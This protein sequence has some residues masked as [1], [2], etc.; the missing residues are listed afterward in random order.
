MTRRRSGYT[1]IEVICA[2]VVGAA[3]L[4]PIASMVQG[5]MQRNQRIR[6]R[7][8]MLTECERLISQV[9]VAV[10]DPVQFARAAAGSMP[11]GVSSSGTRNLFPGERASFAVAISPHDSKRDLIGIT[12]T[13]THDTSG[14]LP[15]G[16]TVRLVTEIARPW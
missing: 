3:A 8:A 11:S 9:R 12:V 10:H 14:M 16:S 5:G 2:T 7:E 4:V 13:T 15:V 6:V 1:L